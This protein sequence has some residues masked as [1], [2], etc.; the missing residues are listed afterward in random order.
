MDNKNIAIVR[1]TNIIPFDGV[2]RPIS[3]IPYL[4]KNTGTQFGFAISDLLRKHEIMP[5]TTFKISEQYI[6]ESQRILKEYLPYMSDYNS[7][8]LW[9]INGL[10]PD[11]S[12]N[13]F[14]NNTF[15]N[16][17]CVIIDGL[18][19]Q[20]EMSNVVSLVPT[21]TAIRGNVKLSSSAIIL[22]REEEYN[23]ISEE[24]KQMLERLNLTVKTFKGE[25]RENVEKALEETGRY[26]PERPILNRERI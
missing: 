9:A 10:V 8:V 16:K 4:K 22:I 18:A 7:M 23:K 21:D 5:K 25:L 13:G 6:K 1:A 3:E 12:E 11:D 20:L 17:N 24:Q 15:S 19:E 26:I 2:V 14:G